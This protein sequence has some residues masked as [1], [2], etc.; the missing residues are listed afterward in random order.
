MRGG[1]IRLDQKCLLELLVQ[2]RGHLNGVDCIL[3]V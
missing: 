3:I 1:V 2:S